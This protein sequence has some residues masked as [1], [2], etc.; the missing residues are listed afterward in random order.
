MLAG[1][2]APQGIRRF[3]TWT[4][5][6]AAARSTVDALTFRAVTRTLLLLHT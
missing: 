1:D 3:A 5:S 2:A 4:D 6:A